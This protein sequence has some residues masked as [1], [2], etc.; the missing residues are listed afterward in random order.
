ME[1]VRVSRTVVVVVAALML[2]VACGRSASVAQ[3]TPTPPPTPTPTPTPRDILNSAAQ[4]FGQVNSAHYQLQVQGNVYLDQQQ[5]LAL[6]GAEG[7]ILRPS[8]AT[9]KANV[10]LGGANVTINMIAVG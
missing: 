9:A 6:R 2:L 8:S 1:R 3:S 4:R 7:D 10:A 5:S